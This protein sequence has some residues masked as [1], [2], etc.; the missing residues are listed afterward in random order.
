MNGNIIIKCFINNYIEKEIFIMTWT[1]KVKHT[2]P[3]TDVDFYTADGATDG[4]QLSSS[5]F[6]YYL[7]TYK[8]TGKFI[9]RISSF[10]EDGLEVTRTLIWKDEATKNEYVQDSRMAAA[11]IA[12]EEYNTLNNMKAIF[13]G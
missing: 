10:S 1:V 9:N 7:T 3:N 12:H 4:H 5:D 2:R 13:L 6:A 11:L 8:E